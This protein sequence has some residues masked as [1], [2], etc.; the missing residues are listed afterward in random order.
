VY[1]RA[2]LD[3]LVALLV[4]ARDRVKPKVWQRRTFAALVCLTVLNVLVS[5]WL[6]RSEREEAGRLRCEQA[7]GVLRSGRLADGPQ[8]HIVTGGDL[9]ARTS[10]S[11]GPARFNMTGE[12]FD[13]RITDGELRVTLVMRDGEGR[14]IGYI[15]ENEWHLSRNAVLEYNFSMD[16][17]EV[18]GLD[19]QIVFQIRIDANTVFLAGDF[20]GQGPKPAL[21]SYRPWLGPGSPDGG[22]LFQYPSCQHLGELR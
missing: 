6:A 12:Q 5:L 3:G 22:R 2:V 7:Y 17:L 1:F 4:L 9:S 16:R 8:I 10:F 21:L 15:R 13:F 20:Y 18:I 14:V 19:N 11:R